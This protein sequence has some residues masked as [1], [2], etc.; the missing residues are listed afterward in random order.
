MTRKQTIPL[1]EGMVIY[2]ASTAIK[3]M[4]RKGALRSTGKGSRVYAVKEPLQ[5]RPDMPGE[6]VQLLPALQRKG[7]LTNGS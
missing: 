2:G 3:E 1:Q 5:R 4:I 7:R 6:L